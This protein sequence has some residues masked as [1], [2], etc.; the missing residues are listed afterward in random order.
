VEVIYFN[1]SG[2]SVDRG[3]DIVVKEQE[4]IS[5]VCSSASVEGCVAA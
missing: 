3:S 5:T 4:R 2:R 1:G